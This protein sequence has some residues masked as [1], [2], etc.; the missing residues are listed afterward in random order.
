MYGLLNTERILLP[1]SFS[2]IADRALPPAFDVAARTG[3]TVHAVAVEALHGT[4]M[5]DGGG[6]VLDD[7]RERFQPIMRERGTT[8][9]AGDVTFVPRVQRDLTPAPA[10][11]RYA[12]DHDI[13]LIVMGTHGQEERWRLSPESVT[14]KVVRKAPCPVLTINSRAERTQGPEALEIG[15]ILV[16]TDFSG[17]SRQA[18]GHAKALATIFDAT[19]DLHHT[20]E[21]T[22]P[23]IF[24]G[25]T[26]QSIYDVRP[27]IEEEV[28]AGLKEQYRSTE[29]HGGNVTFTVKPG[30]ADKTIAAHAEESEADL[31]LMATRGREGP[32]RFLSGSVAETVVRRAPC[33]VLTARCF[34]TPPVG[35]VRDVA[36]S[37]GRSDSNGARSAPSIGCQ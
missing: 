33:P 2:D 8:A 19:V 20:V 10:L 7:L 4:L 1:Y 31:I 21:E 36:L 9:R 15:R 18:L 14:E 12:S 27:N 23:P 17:R 16:P 25:P 30:R 28:V 29:G 37:A 5:P 34:R 11:L 22:L 13:D 24:Y 26:V 6:R 35:S 32:V 3:A